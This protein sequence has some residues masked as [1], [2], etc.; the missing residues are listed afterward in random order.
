MLPQWPLQ[1]VDGVLLC[2]VVQDIQTRFFRFK[3]LYSICC[4]KNLKYSTFLIIIIIS[5]WLS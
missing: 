4:V 3:L 2:L 5:R 1:G